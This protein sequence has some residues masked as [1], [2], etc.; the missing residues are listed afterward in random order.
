[1][2]KLKRVL[3]VARFVVEHTHGAGVEKLGGVRRVAQRNTALETLCANRSITLYSL[4]GCQVD[5]GLP[6]T[7]VRE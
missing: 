5:Y 2:I 7:F 1:M 6:S 3:L 4:V